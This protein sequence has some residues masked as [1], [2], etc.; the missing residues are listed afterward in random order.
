MIGTAAFSTLH[1]GE[2]RIHRKIVD[3]HLAIQPR[4]GG[5]RWDR[6]AWREPAYPSLSWVVTQAPGVEMAPV[7][8]PVQVRKGRTFWELGLVFV[9]NHQLPTVGVIR[10]LLCLL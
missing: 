6:A 2:V 1:W 7:L 5:M 10:L 8:P 9:T 3:G 4:Q